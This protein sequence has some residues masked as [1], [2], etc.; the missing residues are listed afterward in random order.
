[1]N[2]ANILSFI[3]LFFFLSSFLS[4]IINFIVNVNVLPNIIHFFG[5]ILSTFTSEFLK[6]FIPY[7]DWCVKYTLR[8]IG[9]NGCDYCSS[10]GIQEGKPGL[11]SGHMA[12]TS[13]FVVY[14]ILYSIKNK[15]KYSVQF[16]ILNVILLISMGWARITK[17]CHNLLQVL[18]G[19][20]LGSTYAYFFYNI[21]I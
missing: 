5:L 11:P 16:I 13:Y 8:P 1:M 2:I 3:P 15:I 4:I 9:A 19:T 20:L 6:A 18:L 14:N 21:N 7:P 12:S 10:N 17:K